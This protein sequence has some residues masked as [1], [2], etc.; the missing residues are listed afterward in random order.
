[1]GYPLYLQIASRIS[2]GGGGD[3]VKKCSLFLGVELSLLLVIS[4]THYLL[5]PKSTWKL[6]CER[7]AQYRA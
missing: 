2:L 5:A 3:S 1:M 6:I 4:K 7:N